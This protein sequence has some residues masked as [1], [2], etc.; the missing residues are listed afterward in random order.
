[1]GGERAA[2][3]GGRFGFGG[4]RVSAGRSKAA[5]D[6]CIVG[7]PEER[8]RAGDEPLPVVFADLNKVGAG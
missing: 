4:T 8:C 5:G 1:M 6:A 7:M 3:I 2:L